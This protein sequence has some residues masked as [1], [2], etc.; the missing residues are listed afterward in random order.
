MDIIGMKHMAIETTI[1]CAWSASSIAAS[2]PA[3]SSWGKSVCSSSLSRVTLQHCGGLPTHVVLGAN[4]WCNCAVLSDPSVL[5]HPNVD[6]GCSITLLP[7]VHRSPSSTFT[8]RSESPKHAVATQYCTK[9]YHKIR[10]EPWSKCT[11]A[12]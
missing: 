5:S 10:E 8:H 1:G 7:I 12:N 9:G 11:F 3:A 4:V 2:G 6:P